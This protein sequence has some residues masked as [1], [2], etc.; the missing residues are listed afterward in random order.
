MEEIKT[1]QNVGERSEMVIHSTD[2]VKI[3]FG[4]DVRRLHP[5][6]F[7]NS[8]KKKVQHIG[9][10]ETAKEMIRNHL[11][12]EAGLWFDSKG[13]EI[14]SCQQQSRQ[15][16]RKSRISQEDYTPRETQDYRDRRQNNR[17]D[18]TRRDFNPR[19][20]NENRDNGRGN[21]EQRNRQWNEDRNRDNRNRSDRPR[22]NNREV[23][24]SQTEDYDE[25]RHYDEN[26]NEKAPALFYE[27]AH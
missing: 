27:G 26:I 16:E 10:F 19:R 4:G 1:Q 23:N 2:D 18:Y 22:E 14:D 12:Y 3:R 13:E 21:Y 24:N 25:E 17:R 20:K 15:R 8:L 5:V 7:I 11:K 6:P 9:N